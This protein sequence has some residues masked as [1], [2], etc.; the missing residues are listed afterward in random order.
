MLRS[1]LLA[2]AVATA[3][4]QLFPGS[5][6]PP[7]PV[8]EPPTRHQCAELFA[9]GR[10]NQTH[11]QV[12]ASAGSPLLR[13]LPVIDAFGVLASGDREVL[14]AWGSFKA[15][16]N[17]DLCLSDEQAHHCTVRAFGGPSLGVCL[18]RAC[19]A[20]DYLMRYRCEEELLLDSLNATSS[21][22]PALANATAQIEAA[23]H[24][25]EYLA[26]RSKTFCADDASYEL[27]RGARATL[28]ALGSLAGLIAL[29]TLLNTCVRP[30]LELH[31]VA[32]RRAALAEPLCAVA[33]TRRLFAT[34]PPA[35]LDFL[36]GMRVLST[37]YVILG[38][39]FLLSA[40]S[41]SNVVP[42]VGQYMRSFEVLLLLGAFSAVDTFFWLSGLLCARALLAGAERQG[43][44]A[45][46]AGV[47]SALA[48]SAVA[49]AHR[50]ARLTPVYA[51]A[52]FTYAYVLPLAGWGPLWVGMQNSADLEYC[53][54]YWWTN[55]L[56]VNNVAGEDGRTGTSGCMGWTW[57]L[58]NDMQARARAPCAQPPSARA[59]ASAREPGAARSC[60]ARALSPA[61]RTRTCAQ[62]F[63]ISA[64]VLPL[65][66]RAPR[67]VTAV[68]AAAVAT[69]IIATAVLS[70]V[71]T[72]EITTLDGA[73]AKWV[74]G[75][76]Y[77]RC[78]AYAIGC[79]FGIYLH[80]AR[81]AARQA[82]GPR[83]DGDAEEH[84][85]ARAAAALAE[86]GWSVRAHTDVHEHAWR[87]VGWALSFGAL[88]AG[89]VLPWADLREGGLFDHSATLWPQWG[90]DL[91][92]ATQRPLFALALCGVAH[93]LLARRGGVVRELL[94][95]KAWEPLAKLSYGA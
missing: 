35:E 76:P 30:V 62:F 3:R 93:C 22:I 81:R 45:A 50:F 40:F 1:T 88:G 75:M 66:P 12:I 56:Y 53:R 2:C 58:A 19:S 68:F 42:A 73:Y 7:S 41:S 39:Q 5:T 24:A 15:M 46:E 94:C 36:D 52:L 61:R 64:L 11:T 14:S 47:G 37:G 74:Y 54:R 90:K 26:V 78:G 27:S 34:R 67:R 31:G 65:Y 43:A 17:Y 51:C 85:P 6:P 72:L 38:H 13:P 8:P 33:N 16:G 4:A 77:C 18:P 10:C 44:A 71:H 91:Y 79:L 86:A 57:Y 32:E 60:R 92:N 95:A 84:S 89:V 69:S 80:E 21:L 55:L 59:P 82:A 70:R 9:S 49:L 20:Q 83:A 63:A 23:A 29:A 87:V 28:L 48:Q 25:L